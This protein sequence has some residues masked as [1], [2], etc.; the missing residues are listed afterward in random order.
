MSPCCCWP[1]VRSRSCRRTEDSDFHITNRRTFEM[2]DDASIAPARSAAVNSGAHS[3]LASLTILP[4][5][6]GVPV[7]M[8]SPS[9]KAAA[10][11]IHSSASSCSWKDAS[12]VI[13]YVAAKDVVRTF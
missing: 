10:V 4:I 9:C 13:V 1:S 7:R 6:D 5:P 11:H 2:T 12:Y 8:T 3:I